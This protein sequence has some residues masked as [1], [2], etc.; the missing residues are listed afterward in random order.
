MLKFTFSIDASCLFAALMSSSCTFVDVLIVFIHKSFSLIFENEEFFQHLIYTANLNNKH[1]SWK[2]VPGLSFGTT[3]CQI[4]TEDKN[5]IENFWSINELNSVSFLFFCIFA[6]P[7]LYLESRIPKFQPRIFIRNAEIRNFNPQI[8]NLN[9]IL[10]PN[11]EIGNFNPK[12][13]YRDLI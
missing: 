2:N 3:L 12:F 11:P 5:E 8:C 7:N 1:L 10:I 6:F 13:R 9:Q 4:S